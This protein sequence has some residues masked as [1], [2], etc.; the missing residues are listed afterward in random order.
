LV[1][2]RDGFPVIPGALPLIGHLPYLSY[3]P[4]ALLRRAHRE[5]GPLVWLDLGFGNRVLNVAGLEALEILKT[6]RGTNAHLNKAPVLFGDCISVHDGARHAHMRQAMSPSF[7]P[8]GLSAGRVGALTAAVIAERVAEWPRRGSVVILSEAQSIALEVIFRI[9]GIDTHDLAEAVSQYRQF[10]LAGI[11]LSI[12][13]PGFPARRGKKGRAWLDERLRRVVRAVQRGEVDAGL[14][15]SLTKARDDDGQPLGEQ[16]LLDNLRFLTLA[17]HETTSSVVSWMLITC[18]QD[19]AIWSALCDEATA[20]A[21]VPKSADEIEQLPVA[22]ALFR[23]L[24]RLYPPIGVLSRQLNDEFEL[25]GRRIAPGVVVQI[26]IGMVS[27][28]PELFREPDRFD[29]QRWLG[30]KTPLTV[31]EKIA[32]GAGAHFCLGYHLALLEGAQLAV[33]AAQALRAAGL[34]PRLRGKA[35]PTHR[36]FPVFPLGRPTPST[37][38][39]FVRA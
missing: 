33:S 4:A 29:L 20:F 39:E 31:Y 3:D 13:R 23:E 22:E 14:V 16:E 35:R 19:P 9:I 2:E 11:P 7:T 34:R 27:R 25:H 26:C 30:R 18:A 28:D 38:I 32:F 15:E 1:R 6:K 5:L 37:T 21:G 8:R 24:L 10:L 17:A 36:Y 12:D